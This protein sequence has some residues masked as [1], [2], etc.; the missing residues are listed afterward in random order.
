MISLPAGA[1]IWIAAGVTDLRRGFIGKTQ[2]ARSRS[3]SDQ[4]VDTHRRSPDQPDS[5]VAA[6][7]SIFQQ[8]RLR[9]DQRE[10]ADMTWLPLDYVIGFYVR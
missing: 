8:R 5:G 10:R 6:L 4:C 3:L 9:Y 7:E 2:W 1:Q